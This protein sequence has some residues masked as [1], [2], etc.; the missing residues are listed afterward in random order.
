MLLFEPDFCFNSRTDTYAVD[1]LRVDNGVHTRTM[2]QL[3][4]HSFPATPAS[5]TC[6][7]YTPDAVDGIDNVVWLADSSLL[8]PIVEVGAQRVH[9]AAT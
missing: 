6:A 3:S 4:R 1:C 2:L 7:R 9:A 5:L 8:D